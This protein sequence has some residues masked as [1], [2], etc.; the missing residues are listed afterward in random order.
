LNAATR[1]IA[2][3]SI[4]CAMLIASANGSAS[5][6]QK[7]RATATFA[8]GCFWCV[9]EAFDNV[10]GVL[11]TISGYMGGHTTSPTYEQVSSGGTGHA[12]VVQVT[13]DPARVIYTTLLQTFWRNVDA[14]DAGGQFCDRGEQ[15][16]SAIF[17]HSDEQRDQAEASKKQAAAQLAKPIATQIVPAKAF[18][19]AE[20]Y[21][22]DYYKKNPVRYKFYK[23]NCGR[24][25]R[26]QELSSPRHCTSWCGDRTESS[27]V[28]C[29]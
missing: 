9:E 24:A 13:F 7:A 1:S 18:F 20:E 28:S 5:G 25:Q 6:N 29:P 17:F 12:E 22:Q 19:K 14:L 23:W 4:G 15:Y 2:L 27:L 11:S 26:L 16:R 3:T 21:H 8:A 10:E